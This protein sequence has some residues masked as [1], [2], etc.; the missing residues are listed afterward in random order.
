V[1][2]FIAVGKEIVDKVHVIKAKD[3]KQRFLHIID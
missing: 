2:D 3:C 1:D